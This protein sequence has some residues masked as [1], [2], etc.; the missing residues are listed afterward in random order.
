MAPASVATP[1]GGRHAGA[2]ASNHADLGEFRPGPAVAGRLLRSLGAVAIGLT[3]VT[4]MIGVSG[5][6]VTDEIVERVTPPPTPE[7]NHPPSIVESSVTPSNGV[8]LKPLGDVVCEKMTFSIGSVVDIGKDVDDHQLESRWFLDYAPGATFHTLLRGGGVI[9]S[10]ANEQGERL[11]TTC[12]LEFNPNDRQVTRGIHIL[13]F[14]VSDGFGDLSQP[15]KVKQGRGLATYTW[16]IDT[17][18]CV[19]GGQ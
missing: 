14:M 17:S 4:A 12:S 19:G 5:C 16:C 2:V 1:A 3:W 10:Q 8:C 13:K 9:E 18:H 6:L 15:D 11:C 7:P